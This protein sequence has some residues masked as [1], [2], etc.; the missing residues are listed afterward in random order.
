MNL[1][2]TFGKLTPEE[3]DMLVALGRT[4]AYKSG[5]TIVH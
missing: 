3:R 2:A 4:Q 5:E 1:L